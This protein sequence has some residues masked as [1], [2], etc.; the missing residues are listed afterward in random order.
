MSIGI[1]MSSMGDY[2]RPEELLRDADTAM[3]HAK[4]RGKACHVTFD[5]TMHAKATAALWVETELRRAL[6]QNDF[7]VYYQ[8]IISVGENKIT[9]FEAL[10]RWQH[11]E[12]G[13]ITPSEF[14]TI[15][16]ETGLIRPR[17]A[18]PRVMPAT[19]GMADTV[20]VLLR[21]NGQRKCF[22]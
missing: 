15:A 18:F 8:P 16:E 9:G 4:E 11:A 17:K 7:V 1:A 13:I 19:E 12:R 5:S 22:E 14:I 20:S 21:L 10:L 6:E 2:T 3:Y